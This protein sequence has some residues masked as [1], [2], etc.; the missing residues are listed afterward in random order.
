MNRL[1]KRA[2]RLAVF[3]ESAGSVPLVQ[4]STYGDYCASL[5]E[6]YC[7]LDLELRWYARVEGRRRIR[8]QG[9]E[10]AAMRLIPAPTPLPIP[11]DMSWRLRR[12]L[13][14]HFR[15]RMLRWPPGTLPCPRCRMAAGIPKPAYPSRQIAEAIRASH[16]DLTLHVYPCP[17]AEAGSRW[18]LG[19]RR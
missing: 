6:Q 1:R 4:G 10:A 12:R 18:H 3:L 11:A 14:A 16:A 7:R 19:H 9:L 2:A 8:E 5:L 15:R 17:A 13:R